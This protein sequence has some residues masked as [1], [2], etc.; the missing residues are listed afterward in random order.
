MR[1][2]GESGAL[3]GEEEEGGG[4]APWPAVLS[5]P[6]TGDRALQTSVFKTDGTGRERRARGTRFHPLRGRG[7]ARVTRA[8]AGGEE[9]LR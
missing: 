5:S 4:G 2:R 3:A 9:I 6:E 7:R 8:M 1:E